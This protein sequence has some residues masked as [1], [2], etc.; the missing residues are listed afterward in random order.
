VS[1]QAIRSAQRTTVLGW[2]VACLVFAR[3]FAGWGR[4]G[5]AV[6]SAV[7]GVL[8][9][10]MFILTSQAFSQAPGLVDFG[11]LFQRSTVTIGWTWLTLLALHLLGKARVR[12]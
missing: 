1:T 9:L 12:A 8:F 5:W 4:R 6:Y 10:A 11:G 3:R 7:S 2:P